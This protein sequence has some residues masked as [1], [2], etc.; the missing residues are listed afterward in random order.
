MTDN[1]VVKSGDKVKVDYTGKL[2]NGDVFDS[3]KGREPLAFTVGAGQ[4]IQGFDKAVLGMK[5][6]QTKTVTIPAA[7]AY[8]PRRD[9]MV[10]KVDKSQLPAGMNPKVG[11][12]LGMR[13]S[14]GSKMPVTVTSVTDTTMTVDANHFLAGK[15]LIFEI[16]LV[17][18][19]K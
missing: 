13:H 17:E 10:I 8:G 3:S 7:E 5:V 15:D 11:D 12:Q 1:G 9:E 18:I 2:T 6:S 16:T 19:E 14:N 4:M